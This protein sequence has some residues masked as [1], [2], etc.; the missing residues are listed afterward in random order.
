[1]LTPD[2]RESLWR[3]LTP[4]QR[5][6]LWRGLEPQERREMRERL[7]G[8]PPAD[9]EAG[10]RPWGERRP[11]D[12]MVGP[13][14]AAMTPEERQQMRDQIREWHRLRRERLEAERRAVTPPPN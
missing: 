7:G 5:T 4:E 6:D 12:V 2:Q 11:S 13:A 14:R 3:V 8:P 1:M 9:L 10:A